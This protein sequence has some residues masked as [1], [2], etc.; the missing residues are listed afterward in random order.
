MK[1]FT[2]NLYSNSNRFFALS[3]VFLSVLL[4]NSCKKGT[5][6]VA[7]STYLS[8]INAAPTS[9]TYNVYL[10]DGKANAAALPLGGSINYLQLT[11]GNF[12]VKFTTA[13]NIES[14]FTESVSLAVNTIYSYYLISDNNQLDG[15]LVTDAVG[16]ATDKSFVR[17]IN[18]SPDAPA[19]D[20]AVTDAT[21]KLITNQSFK[22][23]SAFVSV[24]PSTYSFDIKE[25]STGT[26]KTKLTS[27]VL[28][29]GVYYTIISRG[30]LNPTGAQEP[31]SAQLIANK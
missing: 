1:T 15:L 3:I 31:F 7:E 28:S 4:L 5:T 21:T 9:A 24:D 26:I 11:P 23:A 14:L 22:S 17:F 18:L 25:T 19:L 27:A 2:K 16:A 6:E 10:N 30:V 13:S 12:S 20:V 29:A 8:I